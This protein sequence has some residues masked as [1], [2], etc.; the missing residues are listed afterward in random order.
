MRAE[1]HNSSQNHILAYM[2]TYTVN[3]FSKW[4]NPIVPLNGLEITG[5]YK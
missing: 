4:L 1:Y 5:A 2:H 3:A